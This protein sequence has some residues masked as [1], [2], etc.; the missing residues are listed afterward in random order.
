LVFTQQWDAAIEQLQSNIE[1]DP[2]FW[3]DHC[4]LGRAYE[5]KRRLPEAIAAFQRALEIDKDNTEIWSG[6]GHAYALSGN[7]VEAQ[8]VLD[9]L[10]ELSAHSYV[11]PYSFAIIYAGLGE[12]DQVFAW[13]DRAYQDRSYFMA[14]YL[15]TD[16]RL[17][18]L[19]GDPRFADLKR[20]IGLPE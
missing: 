10:K 14:V 8:K 6:L 11:A 1:L 18:S 17:D 19:H 7:R 20:R 12:K 4:Y 3:F 5:Q 15:T 9:H 16:A 13:L 2:N